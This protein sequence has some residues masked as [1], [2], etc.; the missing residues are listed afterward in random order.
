MTQRIEDT[1]RTLLGQIGEDPTR[2]GLVDTPRRVAKMWGELVT[3]S[4][5][6]PVLTTF[7][8]NSDGVQCDQMVIVANIDFWSLCE[9]HMLPFI[10]KAS[11]GYIPKD[12]IVGLSKVAR[13]VHHFSRRLQVQERLGSQV[14]DFLFEGLEPEGVCVMLSA[15]HLCMSMRGVRSPGHVTTTH[16][17][18]G[19]IDKEE[20]LNLLKVGGR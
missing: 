2:L 13:A 15:E 18:R 3:N 6:P 11:V 10:G 5:E 9:H 17:I 14:A 16:A 19:N 1:V 8:S 7:P 20:F 12:R 4:A